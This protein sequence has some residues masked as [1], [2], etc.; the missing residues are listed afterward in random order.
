MGLAVVYGGLAAVSACPSAPRPLPLRLPCFV[1][2]GCLFLLADCLGMLFVRH[3]QHYTPTR[4]PSPS[5]TKTQTLKNR[6]RM[7]ST[8][9]RPSLFPLAFLALTF[10][11]LTL[12]RSSHKTRFTTTPF[13]PLPTRNPMNY[14]YLA[15]ACARALSF[16]LLYRFLWP[17]V[18]SLCSPSCCLLLSVS[19][20]KTNT[21]LCFCCLS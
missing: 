17:N 9:P 18:L 20:P 16:A 21:V 2:F 14:E 13:P 12:V 19:C 6:G 15:L 1:W 11:P 3:P 8:Q 10:L 7:H 4:L 5:H